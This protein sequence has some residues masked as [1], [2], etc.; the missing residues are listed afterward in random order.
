MK[1]EDFNARFTVVGKEQFQ[2]RHL[3][4]VTNP[5]VAQLVAMITG[6]SDKALKQATGIVSVISRFDKGQA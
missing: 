2:P 5:A 4:A 3:V 1:P 6:L